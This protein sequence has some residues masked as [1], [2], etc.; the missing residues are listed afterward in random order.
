MTDQPTA[1]KP[2]WN[3]LMGEDAAGPFLQGA[4]CTACGFVTLGVRDLCPECWS[5][6]TMRAKPIG[7]TGTVYS[8]TVIHQVPQGYD[9][10]F[11]VGY[12]DVENG[13][14]VFAHLANTPD[15]L[16]IDAT[17]KLTAATLRR[18]SDGTA[19][20]GPLYKAS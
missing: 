7:R 14:R 3:G 12:V 16:R 9:A 11:A 8:C 18:Q 1:S 19:L 17:V 2:I 13:V 10:P 20:L 4:E 6:A 5:R 15:T